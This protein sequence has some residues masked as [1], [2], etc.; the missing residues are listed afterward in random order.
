VDGSTIVCPCHG[1]V[2]DVTSGDVM[3]GP[4]T[5]PVTSYPT[6]VEGDVIQIEI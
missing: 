3:T 5:E 4:A 6:R 2:F 1:S